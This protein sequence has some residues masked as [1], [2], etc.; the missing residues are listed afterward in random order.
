MNDYE[1]RIEQIKIDYFYIES[2]GGINNLY[3]VEKVDTS[4]GIDGPPRLFKLQASSQLGG[5]SDLSIVE[6][7]Y[8]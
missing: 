2:A 6:V 4:Q 7:N 3:A 5:S 1:D 8:R